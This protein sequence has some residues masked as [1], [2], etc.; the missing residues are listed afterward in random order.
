MSEIS[1]P[2]DTSAARHSPVASPPS[3]ESDMRPLHPAVKRAWTIAGLISAGVFALPAVATAIGA[4]LSE[5]YAL[6]WMAAISGAL[7]LSLAW[8]ALVYTPWAYEAWRF[9]VTP[10]EVWV[11]SG[12]WW[13]RLRCVPRVRIQHVDVESGPID[14]WFGLAQLSLHTAGTIAAVIT[15]PGLLPEDAESLRREL[16]ALEGSDGRVAPLASGDDRG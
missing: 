12:V 13:R 2:G 16:L 9:A 10:G 8:S 3:V 11:S 7:S 14:R 1:G 5:S 4:M 15:I 6:V